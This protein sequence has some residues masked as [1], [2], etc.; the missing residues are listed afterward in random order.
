MRSVAEKYLRK[1]E[2]A[3]KASLGT[4]HTGLANAIET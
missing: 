2:E 1:I 3:E 4:N